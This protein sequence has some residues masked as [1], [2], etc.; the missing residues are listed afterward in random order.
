M[1][2]YVI[3]QPA[4]LGDIFM[5]LKIAKVLQEKGHDI[6][7]PILPNYLYLNDYLN[8]DFKFISINDNFLGKIDFIHTKNIRETDEYI[9]LPLEIASHIVGE[10]VMNAKYRLIN[11]SMDNYLDYFSFK[12]NLEREENLYKNTLRLMD[13]SKY[14]VT[15]RNYVSLPYVRTFQ[16]P[17][18]ET[19]EITYE[20]PMFIDNYNHVFDWCLTIENATEFHTVGTSITFIAEKLDL[21]AKKLFMYKRPE[22]QV[23]SFRIEKSLFKKPWI[24]VE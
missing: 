21:K 17:F 9:Y 20:I 2:P 15:N 1:K 24:F 14:K 13:I 22:A 19:E 18:I 6:I 3:R 8:I 11:I 7:W 4:G 16:K 5:C 12:R 23:H 10:P